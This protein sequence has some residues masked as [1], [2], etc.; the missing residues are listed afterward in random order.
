MF[1]RY[2]EQRF[3]DGLQRKA[4]AYSGKIGLILGQKPWRFP[5]FEKMPPFSLL[6]FFIPSLSRASSRHA[7]SFFSAV[8]S[9]RKRHQLRA[10]DL[11][12]NFYIS[13]CSDTSDLSFVN[14]LVQASPDAS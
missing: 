7:Q 5:I 2:F 10:F 13:V 4:Q 3:L 11:D 14:L 6:T 9:S 8:Q 1:L 12:S